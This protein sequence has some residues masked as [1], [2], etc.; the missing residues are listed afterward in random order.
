MTN[1]EILDVDVR[2]TQ[3]PK[4]IQSLCT[5]LSHTGQLYLQRITLAID[6]VAPR[7][8]T[9]V[10]ITARKLA[11]PLNGLDAVVFSAIDACTLLQVAQAYHSLTTA[12][13]SF[14]EFVAKSFPFAFSQIRT[15]AERPFDNSTNPPSHRDFSALVGKRG[16]E[17]SLITDPSRD[18]L[19]S[20]TSKLLFG[21]ISEG[22]LAHASAH[23]LQKEL[24]QFLFF[25]NNYRSIPWFGGKTPFQ[26]L[27]TF[28]A[29]SKIYSF[30]AYV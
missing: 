5:K 18:A 3:T 29:F 6:E 28:Q 14:V 4:G 16:Y 17:H 19:F 25:H 7:P 22:S 21:G 23:E 10:Y 1:N 26:K 8:G 11:I 9:L 12:A 2:S 24:S 30:S 27:K 15:P 13:V 20:I